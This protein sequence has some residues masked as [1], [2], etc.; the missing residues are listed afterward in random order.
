[1]LLQ[2]HR[3]GELAL[4]KKS[5]RGLQKSFKERVDT[6]EKI[7]KGIVLSLVWVKLDP[8]LR[9]RLCWYNKGVTIGIV[10]NFVA[11]AGLVTVVKADM[12]YLPRA[13]CTYMSHPH[14]VLQKI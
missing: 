2:L 5:L 8:G 14:C 6:W 1:M 12:Q 3:L 10:I 9:R 13:K 7:I 11:E 4:I